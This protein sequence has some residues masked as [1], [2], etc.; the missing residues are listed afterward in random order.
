M[1]DEHKEIDQTD[2]DQFAAET[3]A[4]I[5]R[6]RWPTMKKP[7]VVQGQD[8]EAALVVPTTLGLAMAGLG[9]F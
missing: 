4:E 8:H 5:G 6:R 7:R 2:L 3:L 9:A 1:D